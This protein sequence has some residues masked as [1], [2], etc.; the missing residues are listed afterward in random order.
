[1]SRADRRAAHPKVT[2]PADQ[3]ADVGT[4]QS[5]G[6]A[7]RLCYNAFGEPGH[8]C[9]L[10]V[11]GL[12]SPALLW[13]DRLCCSLAAF[14]PYWVVRFDHRDIGLST[15]LD[16]S[17]ASP[18]ARAAE[19]GGSSSSGGAA[20]P[21]SP[22]PAMKSTDYLRYAYAVLRPGRRT[23]AEVYTLQDMASD[24]FGLLDAIGVA[25]AHVVGCSLG[26][27]VAQCMALQQPQRVRS[28]ALIATHASG[29][30]VSWPPLREMLGLLSLMPAS[31]SAKYAG[32]IAAAT[33]EADKQRLTAARD[34]ERV[35]AYAASFAKLLERLAGDTGRYAFD[36]EAAVRQMRRIFQRSIYTNGC[37]RQFTALLNAPGRAEKL[38]RCIT[39]VPPTTSMA[40]AA[41]PATPSAPAACY[42][43]TIIL[44]GSK[45]ILS[46]VANAKQLAAAIPGSKLYLIEGMGHTLIPELR[47]TYV[48]LISQ[49]VAAGEA[50]AK[51]APTAAKTKPASHL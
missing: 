24:A 21:P 38:H 44:Q 41:A 2:R 32:R 34:A 23:I 12:A 40:A 27:A 5:T 35:E 33:T 51:A 49:N 15:H 43:P 7:V 1:M 29:P 22:P 8:P 50:A 17:P 4:C 16:G 25:A 19:G 11:M 45:D 10:L 36:R 30:Q 20:P 18:S 26:G 42:I 39:S 13:D 9:I 14:G 37:P 48:R 46:P 47:S 3:F 6:R 31:T 28:L